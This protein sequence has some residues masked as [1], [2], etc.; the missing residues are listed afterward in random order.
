MLAGLS[1]VRTY[2]LSRSAGSTSP[3]AGSATSSTSARAGPARTCA[4]ARASSAG[5]T[6]G[7]TSTCAGPT[8]A[9]SATGARE[10]RRILEILL[11]HADHDLVRHTCAAASRAGPAATRSSGSTVSASRASA[12][13]GSGIRAPRSA[14]GSRGPSPASSGRPG[15]SSSTSSTRP[16][17]AASTAALIAWGELDLVEGHRDILLANAEEATHTDHNRNSLTIAVQQNVIHI[18]DPLIV[19][20]DDRCAD[21]LPRRQHLTWLLPVNEV[22]GSP[23]APASCATSATSSRAARA[24][25]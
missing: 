23:S 6:A 24:S 5:A 16:C 22:A 4:A 20:T 17:T 8:G 1:V 10:C 18:A 2:C 25:A 19:R 11:R 12:N 15:R 21:Q 13:T 9:S 14:A 7:T 3:A